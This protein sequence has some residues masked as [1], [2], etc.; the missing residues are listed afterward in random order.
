MF[1]RTFQSI[2][3]LSVFSIAIALERRQ[4]GDAHECLDKFG[5]AFGVH[6]RV[7]D[8]DLCGPQE[9]SFHLGLLEMRMIETDRV[10]AEEPVEIDQALIVDLI[11]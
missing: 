9:I 10:G 1:L 6:V 8:L 4:T 11:I 5:V 3:A 7:R 2:A